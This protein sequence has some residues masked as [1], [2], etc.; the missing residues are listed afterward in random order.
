MSHMSLALTSRV[1]P[2]WGPASAQGPDLGAI[3]VLNPR[4]DDPGQLSIFRLELFES[5]SFK[6][7]EFS[8][9]KC[10]L[11]N[12]FSPPLAFKFFHVSK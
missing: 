9:L 7:F 12:I 8:I 6:W 4:D 10:V 5:N 3:I 11:C 2:Y 1:H